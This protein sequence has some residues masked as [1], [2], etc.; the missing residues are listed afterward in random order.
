MRHLPGQGRRETG[1]H[2]PVAKG[3]VGRGE[4]MKDR[5]N[6]ESR[7]AIKK[8]EG[9]MESDRYTY[10]VHVDELKHG[11]GFSGYAMVYVEVPN[12]IKA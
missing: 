5:R 11:L 12:G 6:V 4:W 10:D 1:S 9:I 8:V 7:R 2:N 3:E